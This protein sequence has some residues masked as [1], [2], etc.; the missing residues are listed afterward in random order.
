MIELAVIAS[1]RYNEWQHILVGPVVV[2]ILRKDTFAGP[3]LCV[4]MTIVI[5][6]KD[7]SVNIII[8]RGICIGAAGAGR[9]GDGRGSIYIYLI[10]IVETLCIVCDG[11]CHMLCNGGM[12]TGIIIIIGYHSGGNTPWPKC[13]GGCVTDDLIY[14]CSRIINTARRKTSNTYIHCIDNAVI[15]NIFTIIKKAVE[16]V[17]TETGKVI[18]RFC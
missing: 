5:Q 18:E 15:F 14:H 13:C 6:G 3:N 7:T 16:V 2:V 9:C 1:G 12:R 17:T 10:D 4:T 8:Q 11:R